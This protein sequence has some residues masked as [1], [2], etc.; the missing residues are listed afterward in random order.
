MQRV[1]SSRHIVASLFFWK[2]NTQSQAWWYVASRK[3]S[4]SSHLHSMC[5]TLTYEYPIFVKNE[6]GCF[7]KYTRNQKTRRG[8]WICRAH[9]TLRFI[10]R[11]LFFCRT[12]YFSRTSTGTRKQQTRVEVRSVMSLLVNIQWTSVHIQWTF[13]ERLCRV[14]LWKKKSTWRSAF[15]YTLLFH[16]SFMLVS[17]TF[18]DATISHTSQMAPTLPRKHRTTQFRETL[19]KIIPNCVGCFLYAMRLFPQPLEDTWKRSSTL[20]ECSL[21]AH[22]IVHWISGTD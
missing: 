12:L 3:P 1:T 5:R 16:H 20:T 21:N 17:N 18:L 4:S 14:L 7:K 13:S 11:A 6:Q 9:V 10:L 2:T 22:W 8:F 19:R 15:L